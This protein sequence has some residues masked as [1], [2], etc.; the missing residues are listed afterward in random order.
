M[1]DVL[2]PSPG[3]NFELQITFSSLLLAG[4]VLDLGLFSLHSKVSKHSAFL[5]VSENTPSCVHQG[6]SHKSL[7]YFAVSQRFR[8]LSY[9]YWQ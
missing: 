2:E 9:F 6:V 1:S 3:S 8:S 5:D 7:H 4:F